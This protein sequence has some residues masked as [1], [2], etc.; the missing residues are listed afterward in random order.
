[1]LKSFDVKGN[2]EKRV[3]NI[4]KN[5]KYQIR[6]GYDCFDIEIENGIFSD[7]IENLK[8][9]FDNYVVY[10]FLNDEGKITL[11]LDTNM[12]FED[13]WIHLPNS[14]CLYVYELINRNL[15]ILWSTI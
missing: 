14:I 12:V 13:D 15:Y 2:I 5:E 4:M 1:M 9:E 11:R 7:T 6:F 3:Y 10:I 8:D